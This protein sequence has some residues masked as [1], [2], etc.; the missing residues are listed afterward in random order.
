MNVRLLTRCKFKA[1][2]GD[3]PTQ[4]VTSL[5]RRRPSERKRKARTDGVS[6]KHAQRSLSGIGSLPQQRRRHVDDL[7]LAA[8]QLQLKLGDR[9]LEVGKLGGKR[10]RRVLQVLSRA[11]ALFAN[12]PRHDVVHEL[13]PARRR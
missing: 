9:D 4:S 2:R 11:S 8:E 6:S 12:E 5:A 3:F 1:T 10:R 7:V 13:A